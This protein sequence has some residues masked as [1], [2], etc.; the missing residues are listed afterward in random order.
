VG[1]GEEGRKES[2][3]GKGCKEVCFSEEACFRKE[4]WRIEGEGSCRSGNSSHASNRS[5]VKLQVRVVQATLLGHEIAGHLPTFRYLLART[6]DEGQ[7][8]H[9]T[10]VSN[11]WPR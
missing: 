3:Y 1:E 4:G 10:R 5:F 7:W 6:S 8:P 9:Q 2:L 11:L